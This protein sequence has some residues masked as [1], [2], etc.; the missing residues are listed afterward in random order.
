MAPKKGEKTSTGDDDSGVEGGTV[1]MTTSDVL[2][3]DADQ[4]TSTVGDD[5]D[6]RRP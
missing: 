1:T 2:S 6:V 3:K 4:K 5:D